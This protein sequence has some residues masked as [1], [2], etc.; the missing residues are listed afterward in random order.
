[1][2]VLVHPLMVG[3]EQPHVL[4]HL[5]SMTA[6]HRTAAAAAAAVAAAAGVKGLARSLDRSGL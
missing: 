2:H 1:M 3:V 4:Q 5:R 6:V